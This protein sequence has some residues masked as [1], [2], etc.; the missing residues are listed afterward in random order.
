MLGTPVL[1]YVTRMI[2]SIAHS[3]PTLKFNELIIANYFGIP[4]NLLHVLR[5]SLTNQ[6]FA[7]SLKIFGS[8]ELI[9]NPIS[10]FDNLGTG[11]AELFL[12]TRSEMIGN[13]HPFPLNDGH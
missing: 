11:V 4:D 10:L 6:A 5:V 8:M 9:G 2:G 12:K 7:Q 13:D 3:S 1:S